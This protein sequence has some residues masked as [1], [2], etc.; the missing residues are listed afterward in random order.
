MINVGIICPSE[1]AERRFLPALKNTKNMRFVGVG[2]AKDNE[3]FGEKTKSKESQRARAERIINE[4]GGELF[5][6][7]ETIVTSDK[8]DAIYIPL[9]PALH[10]KW[11]KL[12]L[13]SGKHVLV[14]KPSTLMVEES[15][16]LVEIARNGNLALHENYMFV[17]HNQIDA[18]NKIIESGILGEV[19]LFRVRFGFPFRGD[20]DFRYNKKLGGGALVDAGG[21]TIKYATMLL[22]DNAKV[23]YAQLSEKK[24]YS[25]DIYGSGA[26]IN[27]NGETVQIAFGMDNDYKCELEV[28]GSKASLITD[29]VLTAPVGYIPKAYIKTGYE[30]K[31][32]TLPED[33][34]FKKSIEFF[35]QCIIDND[36]REKSFCDIIKQS[37]MVD[38]FRNK[39]VKWGKL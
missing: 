34:S 5:E 19:R 36:K 23:A 35:S 9:P 15:I 11:S 13:Q 33:D 30:T 18:L 25:V 16:E 10:F 2:I 38:E 32:I 22:G 28:W 20:N 39:A 3:R 26:L 6:G 4:F 27:D 17:F 37:Q 24:G 29:R 1:I 31:E 21:Y 7:Y 8:V 12:A 14:E